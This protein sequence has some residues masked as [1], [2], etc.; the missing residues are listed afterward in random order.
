MSR[1]ACSGNNLLPR[2]LAAGCSLVCCGQQMTA[3]L[4]NASKP[5]TD[6]PEAVA[7]CDQQGHSRD[8]PYNSEHG[9]KLRVCFRFNAIHASRAICINICIARLPTRPPHTA[10]LRSDRRMPRFELDINRSTRSHP[11][12]LGVKPELSSESVQRRNPA[13]VH[14]PA[15]NQGEAEMTPPLNRR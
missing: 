1:S 14:V 5:C 10:T 6:A 4:P 12:V 2:P 8:T 15:Q 13:W 7:V 3:P 9:Q 11:T